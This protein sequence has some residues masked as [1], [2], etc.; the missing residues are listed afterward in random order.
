MSVAM[1]MTV[2]RAVCLLRGVARVDESDGVAGTMAV[3][4][5][6]AMSVPMT[7]RFV[8]VVVVAHGG[9]FPSAADRHLFGA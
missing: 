6:V 2:T 3:I 8:L 4:V 5:P 7:M 1:P 9:K